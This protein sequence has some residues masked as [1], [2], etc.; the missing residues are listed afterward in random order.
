MTGV[1]IFAAIKARQEYLA[2]FRD[3]IAK[4]GVQPSEVRLSVA[5]L[6]T[7]EALVEEL[8]HPEEQR[9]LYAIDV[10]ESLD[11]RHLVTPLLLHHESSAVR[12]RALEALKETRKDIS[13]RWVPTIEKMIGDDSPEVRAAAIAT[14]ASIRNE[15]AAVLARTLIN[16]HDPRIAVTA[17]VALAGSKDAGD[18]KA[19][20]A[21]L[22][23]LAADTRETAN[24][25]RRDLAAA[26]RQV[27]DSRSHDLLIPLLHDSD[28]RVAEEAMHSVRTLGASD[29][30]FAPT[31]VSLLGNRRLKSGARE[32]LVGYGQ[33]VVDLLEYFL[34]DTDEDVWVR[35]HIP[36]TLSRI[37]CQRSMDILVGMLGDQDEFLRFKVLTG[38]EKL[39]RSH[40]SLR[41][42]TEPVEKRV[43]RES[44]KYYNRLGLH[45]NLFVRAKMPNTSVLAHALEEK[46]KRTIDRI[47]RLLGLL[48][49]WKDIAAAR[50]AVEHGDGRARASALEYL[51]NILA[52]H[53]R[54]RLMPILEDIPLEEKVR[55]GNVLL[56]TR[57]RN[58]EETLLELIND[59][60]QVVAAAAVDLI[61]EKELWNLADDVEF[62]LAH[63][64]PKDWYVFESAS[65]TLA[66][67]TLSPERRRRR[68][69]EPLPA[70]ALVG[71]MRGLKLFASVSVDELF[72]IAGTG[73]QVRHDTGAT[74]LREGAAP[75]TLHLVLDGRVAAT[76]R[77]TGAREIDAP[78]ALG[79]EEALDGCVMGETV[80]T[81]ELTVSL[82]LGYEQLRTLLAD[83]T[84]LVQGLFR[85]LAERRS[86]R[87]G[88]IRTDWQADLSERAG[89]LTRIQKVRALQAIPLFSEVS[90]TELLYLAA[91]AK[92]IPLEHDAVLAD[93]TGPFGLGIILSGGLA[94]TSPDPTGA[95][96]EKPA[97]AT[98]SAS[99]RRW[100]GSRREHRS[101]NCSSPLRHPGRRFRSS[102]TSCSICSHS[103]P[104]CFSRSSQRSS[105]GEHLKHASLLERPG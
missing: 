25:I 16:D 67:R 71:R 13:D 39:R 70:T 62:V 3:T 105:I 99:M 2:S 50:W 92:Q 51:D 43:Q 56:K 79:F 38:I 72:R 8:A 63:R 78:A 48:Y 40:P 1:W 35:R 32:A 55:R 36:A 12:A 93:E 83:N 81:K 85:T 89:E 27:G 61:G 76:G 23:S 101:R 97:R 86:A 6:S 82:E 84:G 37:P 103:G 4:Q 24:L 100:P 77:H 64:G 98:L 11:K 94:L 31:L 90:A 87:P 69:V 54:H 47:Y 53:I 29:V 26:I 20:E 59:D 10:L 65:W 75:D 14:L 49:P 60:D 80:K 57:P 19:A 17:A 42:D 33:S 7:I 30:L 44:V 34:N 45:H 18:R 9:V 46:T 104:T 73:H 88:F 91:I 102:A 74:L 41:F 95:G 52:S 96:R 5:D 66:S 28:F 68:W 15:D 22:S 21:T 58:I